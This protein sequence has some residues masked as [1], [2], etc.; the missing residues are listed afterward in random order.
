MWRPP[1][2]R[3]FDLLGLGF[4]TAPQLE[5]AREVSLRLAQPAVLRG[6]SST[7]LESQSV[8]LVY[9]L[10]D[11]DG[12]QEHLPWLHDLYYGRLPSLA[13]EVFATVM[14][15]S[16]L[17]RNG[18]NV[19]LLEGTGSRYEWHLDSNP[20]T[21]VLYFTATSSEVGGRLLFRDD[22]GAET[23]VSTAIGELLLFD[24]RAVPHAVEEL[25]TPEPRISAPMNFFVAG[26]E[27]HR[28]RDLDSSLYG[29]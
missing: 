20:L 17:V 4:V 12:I 11:G 24:A 27:I 23:A 2:F 5:L 9:R 7:S 8:E 26:N 18:V 1:T 21:G 6:G 29:G 13:T 28:P 15:P 25:R 22:H 19:N 3:S 10:L 14:M 16:P